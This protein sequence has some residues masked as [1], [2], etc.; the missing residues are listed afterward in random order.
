MAVSARH[1][2]RPPFDCL[3]GR[4]VLV[5]E[6][7][8]RPADHLTVGGGEA[9]LR[10][11][12]SWVGPQLGPDRPSRSSDPPLV[13]GGLCN[14]IPT[15]QTAGSLAVSATPR[16]RIK[17]VIGRQKD[18]MLHCCSHAPAFPAWQRC[19]QRGR[20]PPSPVSLA[21][22]SSTMAVL[23]SVRHCGSCEAAPDCQTVA[24]SVQRQHVIAGQLD[25]SAAGVVL[26]PARNWEFSR[27]PVL[28]DSLRRVRSFHLG[29][30]PLG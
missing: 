22:R 8:H 5:A 6:A 9:R 26:L 13:R 19:R 14:G 18:G 16:R 24:C 20:A 3:F 4:A 17:A 27:V 21:A 15:R 12:L 10:K 7:H 11:Q 1:P 30:Q 25:G 23:H 2:H 29:D 28:V